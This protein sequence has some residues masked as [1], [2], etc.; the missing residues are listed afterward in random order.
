MNKSEVTKY[1]IIDSK[2][3]KNN[4]LVNFITTSE[5]SF[6]SF[7]DKFKKI[8]K[9][10]FYITALIM[11]ALVFV[12]A[13]M[14]ADKT[15]A[16]GFLSDIAI[17]FIQGILGL[18]TGILAS[19][20]SFIIN[21]IQ[22]AIF[23]L[24][25]GKFF[26]SSFHITYK[27]YLLWMGSIFI[28]LL[29]IFLGAAIW[30]RATKNNSKDA[31][32]LFA[33]IKGIII[34][35]MAPL[36]LQVLFLSS[37]LIMEWIFGETNLVNLYDFI[38]GY[39]LGLTDGQSNITQLGLI[40]A[41]WFSTISVVLILGKFALFLAKRLYELLIY[42]LIAIP[43]V[44]A[45]TVEDGGERFETWKGVMQIK[46]LS[47]F[48]CL[49]GYIIAL[50]LMPLIAN[51]LINTSIDT[52]YVDSEV[53]TIGITLLM[54]IAIFWLL[55]S[56]STEWNF[57][58]TPKTRASLAEEMNKVSGDTR[59][60]FSVI[61]RINP[62][63]LRNISRVKNATRSGR[64]IYKNNLSKMAKE[65]KG[66]SKDSLAESNSKKDYFNKVY[67]LKGED[68]KAAE[69]DW[70]NNHREIINKKQSGAEHEQVIR[71]EYNDKN[72]GERVD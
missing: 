4:G 58:I 42:G 10:A 28:I 1:K 3:A 43:L 20:A 32:P 29:I 68:K 26:W 8:A 30:R 67:G 5:K 21:F 50:M 25:S 6:L 41:F 16:R 57:I 2:R 44:T 35:L 34:F 63:S 48:F 11:V 61:R 45:A 66:R 33:M 62:A 24:F 54:S 13:T 60:V 55:T 49:L 14:N 65:R 19:L 17:G 70:L 59:M 18:I 56:L 52:E 36:A 22:E 40:L 15:S 46:I 37:S 7:K 27:Q 47:P 64:N 53:F 31:N 71:D 69:R 51:N 72:K 38:Y 12:A 39:T 23:Q 9:K